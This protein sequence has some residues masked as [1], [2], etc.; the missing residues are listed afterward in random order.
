MSA[1]EAA[2][3]GRLGVALWAVLACGS[4]D[5]GEPDPAALRL[6]T[7]AVLTPGG[8]WLLVV[9]SNLDG[10]ESAATLVALDLRRLDEALAAEPVA[11]GT[12]T[13]AGHVC[14][15]SAIEAGLVECDARPLIDAEKTL[16]LPSGSGNVAVDRPFGASG[17]LRLL[18]PS[19]RERVVTWI[20]AEVDADGGLSLEC[21]QDAADSCDEVHALRRKDG[22]GPELPA[23]PAR[24]AVDSQGFRYAYLPHLTS[25]AMTLIDLDGELGPAITDIEGDFFRGDPYAE[26]E[27]TYAGGFAAV[28]RPC[29]P[30]AAPTLSRE[31]SRPYVYTSER[32]WPGVKVFTV[33]VGLDVLQG[34]GDVALVDP[35]PAIVED[36]PYVGDLRFDD[37]AGDRLLVVHTTPPALSLVDTSID[38]DGGTRD[39]VVKTVP[40]CRNPN[41]LALW[42]PPAGE[43]LAFV[44]C[45]GDD[46]VAAVARDPFEP[47]ATIA[48]G[49]GPNELVVDAGRRRL[50]VVETLRG[51]MSVIDLD[52][53]SAGYLR[54]IARVGV[55]SRLF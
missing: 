11:P 47:V 30:A 55:R 21:G 8:E 53:G 5:P 15:W 20:D 44:S 18:I 38:A 12:P 39:A 6:P 22:D 29:D 13:D 31:C 40:L 26:G 2:R 36:R 1:S 49:D 50:Y 41:I 19:G 32:F 28:T 42:D 35:N 16:R 4:N 33:A 9:N 23:D 34:L 17:P 37:A 7:G 25:S 54:V 45:Y 24:V 48:V 14:R 51:S 27:P 10:E 46:A 43:R 3:F 52:R